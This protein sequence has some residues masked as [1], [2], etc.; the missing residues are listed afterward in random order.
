MYVQLNDHH[1]ICLL[2]H[3]I[4]IRQLSL[5]RL[6]VSIGYVV[7][8]ILK[9]IKTK[10]NPGSGKENAK[11]ILVVLKW[12]RVNL[13]I[14]KYKN[15]GNDHHMNDKPLVAAYHPSLKSLSAILNKNTNLPYKDKGVKNVSTPWAMVSSCSARKLNRFL[16]KTKLYPLERMVGS[17]KC[18]GKQCKFA[19][20][21]LVVK[22]SLRCGH[23][24]P[25]ISF[26]VAC[27]APV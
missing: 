20:T 25:K 19:I 24:T 1:H 21:G 10:W 2:T 8:W 22:N 16:V 7:P 6:F 3:N 5:A 9:I 17:Y 27:G 11:K 14:L 26:L 18:K 13:S 12:K 23:C 4:L 15:D